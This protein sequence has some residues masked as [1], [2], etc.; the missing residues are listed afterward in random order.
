VETYASY[1]SFTSNVSSRFTVMSKNPYVLL[2]F[3][4]AVVSLANTI[5]CVVMSSRFPDIWD[6]KKSRYFVS[7]AASCK[8]FMDIAITVTMCILVVQQQSVISSRS[9]FLLKALF[10]WTLTTGLLTSIFTIVYFATYLT[11]PT[12]TLYIGIYLL[13]TKICA[14][15][16][17]ASLNTRK[18]LRS[19]SN[20]QIHLVEIF[21]SRKSIREVSE[22]E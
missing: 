3:I 9:K 10:V 11:M 8:I 14:N 17:L 15:G 13:R 19:I 16:M 4:P 20:Q 2:L 6:I 7:M 21:P 22:S 12:N 18:A 5:G 1:H